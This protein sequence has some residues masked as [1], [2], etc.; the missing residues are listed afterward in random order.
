MTMSVKISCSALVMLCLWMTSTAHAAFVPVGLHAGDTYRLVFMTGNIAVFGSYDMSQLDSVAQAAAA[1]ALNNGAGGT[2]T[3]QGVQWK[4]VVSAA[5]ITAFI[6]PSY[7]SAA[8]H[9]NLGNSEAI[10]RMDGTKVANGGQFWTPNHLAAMNKDQNGLSAS[11][12]NGRVLT[13][14]NSAGAVAGGLGGLYY[15][16][17]FGDATAFG[18]NNSAWAYTSQTTYSSQGSIYVMSELLTVQGP[19]SPNLPP[20]LCGALVY[21][22]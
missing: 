20:S 5:T 14:S 13:G 4:A 12:F 18:V 2:G 3:A 17:G 1:A 6:P 22:A 10:Y 16:V 19:L 15:G 11:A 9:L 8:T 7:V 21:W